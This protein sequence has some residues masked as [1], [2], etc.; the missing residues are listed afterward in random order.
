MINNVTYPL[1]YGLVRG[2]N[3][4][5]YRRLL[6]LIE[7]IGLGMNVTILNRRVRLMV[8]FETAF[9]NASKEFLAGN[10]VSCCFSFHVQLEKESTIDRRGLEEDEGAEFT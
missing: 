7:R 9:I 4:V 1:L 6:Y 3:Q 10:N 8:D 5:L 2:K